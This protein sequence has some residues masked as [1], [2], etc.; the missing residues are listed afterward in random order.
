MKESQPMNGNH[1]A[2][3][4][5]NKYCYQ[6]RTGVTPTKSYKPAFPNIDEGAERSLERGRVEGYSGI[7]GHEPNSMEKGVAPNQSSMGS[8]N[9]SFKDNV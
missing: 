3:S 4:D 2:P 6:S 1:P 8:M 9:N 7:N 5:T